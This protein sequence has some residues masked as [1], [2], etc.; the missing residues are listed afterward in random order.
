MSTK[1]GANVKK[2]ILSSFQ[3]FLDKMATISSKTIQKLD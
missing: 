3:M 1:R 2:T